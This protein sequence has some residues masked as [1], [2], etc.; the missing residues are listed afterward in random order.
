M[1]IY[2][3]AYRKNRELRQLVVAFTV[4]VHEPQATVTALRMIAADSNLLWAEREGGGWFRSRLVAPRAP[5]NF[6]RSAVS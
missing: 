2:L 4:M 1:K 5:F 3:V 6:L